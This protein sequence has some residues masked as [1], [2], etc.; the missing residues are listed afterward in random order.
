[1]NRGRGRQAIFHDSGYYQLFLDT[2]KE[3][4]ERFD[5]VIHAYCLMGNHY[6]LLIETPGA[7]LGRIMRHINGVYTQRYNRIKKTDG[8][9][10]RGRYKAILVDED[11]Y[12][13]QLSRYIHR[14]PIEVKGTKSSYLEDY[15]WSSYPSYIGKTVAPS[16]LYQETTYQMLG[17][18]QRY[19]GYRAYVEAGI[20]EDIKRYYSKGNIAAILGDKA[21]RESVHEINETLDSEVLQAALRHRPK[22]D[23]IVRVVADAFKLTVEQIVQPNGNRK[24][25][26]DARKLS[27]YYCQKIGDI[28]LADIAKGFGLKHVGSASRLIHDAKAIL[29]N[30][31]IKVHIRKIEKTFSVI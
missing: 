19:K 12:L 21:F 18:K 6:H 5:A 25:R 28:S 15:I 3:A 17:H 1:M 23:A 7:N 16:W 10:F 11:A 4:H 24:V 31:N 26:N 27:I 2:L 9:L 8:P 14:N 20:D 30:E 22:I 13:L 29:E